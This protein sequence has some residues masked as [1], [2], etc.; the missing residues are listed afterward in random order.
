MD[1]ELRALFLA[2]ELRAH[3]VT[4]AP[5]ARKRLVDAVL[6]NVCRSCGLPADHPFCDAGWEPPPP[7]AEPYAEYS[8]TQESAADERVLGYE[9]PREYAGYYCY[10]KGQPRT[11]AEWVR[12]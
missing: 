9:D 11:L 4:M 8:V 2:T 10:V 5:G 6:E 12:K 1:D 3:L 7:E